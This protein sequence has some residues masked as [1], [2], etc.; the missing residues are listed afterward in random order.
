MVRGSGDWDIG[1]LQH[2]PLE[3]LVMHLALEGLVKANIDRL[4]KPCAAGMDELNLH[5]KDLDG[6]GNQPHLMDPKLVQQEEDGD[7]PRQ[8]CSNVGGKD[9]LDPI[10]HD[11]L[12]ESCHLVEAVDAA[13][14]E[15]GNLPV[16]NS[17]VGY[18]CGEN[19]TINHN[20]R[21]SICG[22]KRY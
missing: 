11:L 8:R 9:M 12:I 2:H 1:I 16:G 14:G 10:E 19:T 18:S 20:V 5:A 17:S 6:I 15:G 13:R 21:N 7:N 3:E 22:A 4:D